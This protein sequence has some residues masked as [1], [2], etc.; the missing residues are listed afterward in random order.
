[1]EKSKKMSTPRIIKPGDKFGEED[2]KSGIIRQSNVVSKSSVDLLYLH[3]FVSL[4][5]KVLWYLGVGMN[6]TDIGWI[7]GRG[8]IGPEKWKKLLIWLQ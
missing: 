4:V 6:I 8:T 7:R 1:M 5:S 2:L 3:K